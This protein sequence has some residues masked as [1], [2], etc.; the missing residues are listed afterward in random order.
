[1]SMKVTETSKLHKTAIV[2]TLKFLFDKMI[3]DGTFP[4]KLKSDWRTPI[5][6]YGGDKTSV[7]DYRLLAIHSVF[8]KIFCSILDKR[9]CSSIELDDAQNG[10]R[11]NR[12]GTNN[13]LILNNLIRQQSM[14]SGAYIIV[15]DFSKA[16]DRCHNTFR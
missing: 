9:I 2:I 14:E 5:F 1:M 7:N 8:R 13:A 4:K 12:R 16:F 11:K 15:V 3:D 6:K 10:F